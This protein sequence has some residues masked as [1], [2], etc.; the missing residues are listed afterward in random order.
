MRRVANQL[1]LLCLGVGGAS[2][3]GAADVAST[4]PAAAAARTPAQTSLAAECDGLIGSAVK[5]SF[6]WGWAAVEPLPEAPAAPAPTGAAGAEPT[7]EKSSER[8]PEAAP[9]MPTRPPANRRPSPRAGAKAVI[10][11]KDSA[12]L[13][14]QLFLIGRRLNEPRFLDAAYE[15]A[16]GLSTI[17]SRTGQIRTRGVLGAMTGAND[18]PIDVPDRAATRTVLALLLTLLDAD[19]TSGRHDY[20][21]LRPAASHA[22]YWLAGQMTAAGGWPSAYPPNAA[23]GKAYRLVFLDRRDYRDSALTLLLA[24][25]VLQSEPL[26]QLFD[27]TADELQVLRPID[28]QTAERSFWT[29]AYALDGE[30]T[31]K[32]PE[33]NKGYD[34]I[35]GRYAAETLL[36][37]YVVTLKPRYDE[38][39]EAAM[40]VL[41]K[42]PR[43]DG[44]YARF[45]DRSSQKAVPT[46]RPDE[47]SLF[48]PPAAPPPRES[49][50]PEQ[51]IARLQAASV[52]IHGAGGK[53]YGDS[54][55]RECPLL[56]RVALVSSG[57]SD[58]ALTDRLAERAAPAARDQAGDAGPPAEG[59]SAAV[60]SLW[61]EAA[62]AGIFT[63]KS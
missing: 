34:L 22:A 9:P 25:E 44:H 14:L 17:Q 12:A 11:S 48:S 24:G 4:R 23:R 59:F 20:E 52:E 5:T 60:R 19:R 38:V 10:D 47:G 29:T 37:G 35:A 7:P 62:A 46:T 41:N 30:P 33:L 53:S 57:L 61:M 26:Q 43:S 54:L 56:T 8:T 55:A 45:Y 13:G 21:R 40:V 42:F 1:L 28:P 15:V 3:V 2:N 39:F 16:R 27:R 63:E 32:F 18:P 6:G 50:A 49:F 58:D 36:A 31:R 51:A